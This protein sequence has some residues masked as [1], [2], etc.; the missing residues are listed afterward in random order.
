MEIIHEAKMKAICPNGNH[1]NN[2]NVKI[3]VPDFIEVETIIEMLESYKDNKIFQEDLTK[4]LCKQIQSLFERKEVF[5]ELKGEHLGIMITTR[6][7]YP[8]TRY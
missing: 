1:V 6:Y 8:E 5:I 2:Y 4:V 7:S 3:K